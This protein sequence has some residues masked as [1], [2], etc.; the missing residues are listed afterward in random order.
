MWGDQELAAQG[1]PGGTRG[2]S[3][4]NTPSQFK[5]RRVRRK[6]GGSVED[7]R[8]Q[9]VTK[10]ETMIRSI[11]EKP[12]PKECRPKSWSKTELNEPPRLIECTPTDPIPA[13]DTKPHRPG[14]I[15]EITEHVYEASDLEA[16][17]IH[18]HA[19]KMRAGP[20]LGNRIELNCT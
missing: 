9:S 8:L 12:S 4:Q 1:R 6:S 17:I 13:K 15:P 5:R 14:S 10:M 16:R 20:G 2:R 7:I 11:K 18:L 3:A 19:R